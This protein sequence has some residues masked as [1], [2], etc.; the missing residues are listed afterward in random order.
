MIHAK[1][2]STSQNQCYEEHQQQGCPENYYIYQNLTCCECQQGLISLNTS[3]MYCYEKEK[4]KFIGRK[5]QAGPREYEGSVQSEYQ[6][7]LTFLIILVSAIFILYGF[8]NYFLPR[9]RHAMIRICHCF[10]I[11]RKLWRMCIHHPVDDSIP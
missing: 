9:G 8:F 3:D 11:F 1:M 6:D 7:G 5:L 10:T 4:A 2:N